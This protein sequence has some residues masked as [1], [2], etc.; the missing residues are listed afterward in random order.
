MSVESLSSATR[1]ERNS[2]I[3]IIALSLI[4]LLLSYS[5]LLGAI[6]KVMDFSEAPVV[7]IFAIA[8]NLCLVL[9]QIKAGKTINKLLKRPYL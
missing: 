4:G 3:T 5:G 8:L 1:I 7:L 9:F 6:A 2:T